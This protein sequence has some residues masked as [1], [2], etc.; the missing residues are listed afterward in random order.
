[1]KSFRPKDD[2]HDSSSGGGHNESVDFHGE[3]R[4]NDTH[5]STTD[6]DVRLYRKGKGK[7]SRLGVHGL[8][9]DGEP[10]RFGG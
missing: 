7:E 9:F 6:P 1:M 4:C 10:P 8:R 3:Q 2:G 5:E